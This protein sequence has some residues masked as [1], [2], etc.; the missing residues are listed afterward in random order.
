MNIVQNFKDISLKLSERITFDFLLILTLVLIFDGAGGEFIHSI[1]MGICIFSFLFPEIRRSKYTFG[2]MAILQAINVYIMYNYTDNH[3]FLIC[4]ILIFISI[5]NYSKSR[6]VIEENRYSHLSNNTARLLI[7]LVMLLAVYWKIVSNDYLSGDFFVYELLLDD[8]FA[9]LKHIFNFLGLDT[10]YFQLARDNAALIGT[11][12]FTYHT[13]A[14]AEVPF[15]HPH[16]LKIISYIVTYYGITIEFLIGIFFLLSVFFEKLVKI[17]SILLLIFAI[18]VYALAPVYHFAWS[19]MLLNILS[20]KESNH[21]LRSLS[22]IVWFIVIFY[23][24][25]A[26][27]TLPQFLFY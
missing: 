8:R 3:K 16:Y 1:L 14:V 27:L 20:L 2:I 9:R 10:S 18:T 7:S 13:D 6:G 26:Q 19:L 15:Y 23:K 25:V 21:H 24:F 17:G 22:F 5:L 11:S 4:Y 12:H